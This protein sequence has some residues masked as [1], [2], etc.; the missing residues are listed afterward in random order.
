MRGFTIVEMFAVITIFSVLLALLLPALQG[1]KERAY[2]TIC[3]SQ[4]RQMGVALT[5]YSD[6]NGGWVPG[7]ESRFTGPGYAIWFKESGAI[8]M[9]NLITGGYLTN[10][11]ATLFYC[12]GGAHYWTNYDNWAFGYPNN[13]GRS[14]PLSAGAPSGK[15]GWGRVFTNYLLRRGE[16]WAVHPDDHTGGFRISDVTPNVVLVTDDFYYGKNT[17]NLQLDLGT[18]R[19]TH[20]IGINVLQV[21][22]AVKMYFDPNRDLHSGATDDISID[23]YTWFERF[24][25]GT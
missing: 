20:E 4:I 21:N 1:A 10:E 6:A 2:I 9:G 8:G 19:G 7:V 15:T 22:G 13:W 14:V 18:N 12:P 17:M 5:V 3:S 23:I 24:D 25:T 11:E 16:S